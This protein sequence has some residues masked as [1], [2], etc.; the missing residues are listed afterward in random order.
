MYVQQRQ[1]CGKI[2]RRVRYSVH[3]KLKVLRDIDH[4]HFAG[5]EPIDVIDQFN[6][7]NVQRWRRQHDQLLPVITKGKDKQSKRRLVLLPDMDEFRDRLRKAS[8]LGPHCRVSSSATR[9]HSGC[10][11]VSKFVVFPV[12]EIVVGLVGVP[13]LCA[14]WLG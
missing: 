11:Y 10:S 2:A 8:G 7:T 1:P 9:L 14:C 3:Q 5:L 13:V 6:Q 12:L 4:A